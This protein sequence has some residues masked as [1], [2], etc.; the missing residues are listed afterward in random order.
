LVVAG[1]SVI[2]IRPHGTKR[3][4]LEVW[5]PFQ[6]T[7]PDAATLARWFRHGEGLAVIGGAVSGPLEIPDFDA[8]ELF[9]P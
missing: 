4:A 1:L 5:R 8:P 2:P 9:P 6:R 7:R 3:P